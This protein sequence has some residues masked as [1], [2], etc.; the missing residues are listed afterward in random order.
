MYYGETVINE[1]YLGDIDYFDTKFLD[2]KFKELENIE[3]VDDKSKKIAQLLNKMILNIGSTCTKAINM[4]KLYK[5]NY[6]YNR[7]ISKYCKKYLPMVIDKDKILIKKAIDN[8]FVG[9][10]KDS[11]IKLAVGLITDKIVPR[12]FNFIKNA[13][14]K[15]SKA[16]P[17]DSKI[18]TALQNLA[19]IFYSMHKN[20]YMKQGMSEKD[21]INKARPKGL[22]LYNNLEN[23]VKKSESTI[24]WICRQIPQEIISNIFFEI[25][26]IKFRSIGEALVT[27]KQSA[28]YN[29]FLSESTK[30]G[31]QYCFDI[32]YAVMQDIM[33]IY[34]DL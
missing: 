23:K 29:N 3:D 20:K 13:F 25:C 10:I 24:T 17:K 19:A 22:G 21:A 16:D 8:A 28:K 18:K 32:T 34:K 27:Y 5:S 1:S 11:F 26:P 2:N 33:Q 31:A 12:E 14:Q 6:K 30:K 9:D 15:F 7:V 4:K